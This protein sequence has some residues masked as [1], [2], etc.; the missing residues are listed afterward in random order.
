MDSSVI[1]EAR[2]CS[3]IL[4]VLLV[5]ERNITRACQATMIDRHWDRIASYGQPENT[6]NLGLMEGLNNT[7]PFSCVGPPVTGMK[8][9][10]VYSLCSLYRH[11]HAGSPTGWSRHDVGNRVLLGRRHSRPL[12]ESVCQWRRLWGHSRDSS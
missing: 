12:L 10:L 9:S 1:V 3:G 8:S 11:R 6:A 7:I 4:G 2:T 5:F